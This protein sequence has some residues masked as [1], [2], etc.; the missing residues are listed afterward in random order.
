MEEQ[1]FNYTTFLAFLGAAAWLPHIF[2]WIYKAIVKPHI[3]ITIGQKLEV[4]YTGYGPI[5]NLMC[6]ISSSRCDALVNK[7]NIILRHEKG[8]ET[9]LTWVTL[10]ES[11]SQIRSITGTTAEVGKYQAAIALKVGT[12]NLVEKLI[13]F[14]D[15]EF[16]QERDLLLTKAAEVLNHSKKTTPSDYKTK[17]LQSKELDD[18]ISYYKQEIN[19]QVGK[20]FGEIK[21]SVAQSKKVSVHP[22]EFSLTK[23]DIDRLNKNIDEIK[24]TINDAIS[25][26]EEK[27][28]EI[29][30]WIRPQITQPDN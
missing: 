25:P 15:F 19:W 22:F 18:L 24:R 12:V 10:N 5:L 4:G 8:Q 1:S 9:A 7:I 11:I 30:D 28:G 26:P 21:V 29:W 27:K 3:H 23:N 16:Q 13:G 6:A 17:V 20:Y 2:S 14:Q